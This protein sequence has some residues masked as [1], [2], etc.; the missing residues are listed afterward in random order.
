MKVVL[1]TNVLVAAFAARGLCEAVF[2]LCLEYHEIVLSE[3][4]LDEVEEKLSS[5][6]KLPEH[7]SRGTL[8]FLRNHSTFVVPND[9]PNDACRDPDDLMVLGTADTGG[10]SFI[11]TGDD[12]LLS[13][14]SFAGIPILTPRML[15]EREAGGEPTKR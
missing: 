8:D 9:V 15:W 5:K 14:D 7:I 11:V 4:L 6:L 3:P 13:L 1:D 2:E 12:D 10:A